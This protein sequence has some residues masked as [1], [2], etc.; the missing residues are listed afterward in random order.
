MR[1]RSG[2][3]EEAP[4]CAKPLCAL[5]PPEVRR[6]DK[7]RPLLETKMTK[8]SNFTPVARKPR[9]SGQG[10]KSGWNAELQEL[11][12][13]EKTICGSALLG[14]LDDALSDNYRN[15]LTGNLGD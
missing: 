13:T 6:V 12:D 11:L 5:R 10:C 8:F 9:R 4:V 14:K 2:D 15:M 1:D 3:G 7:A